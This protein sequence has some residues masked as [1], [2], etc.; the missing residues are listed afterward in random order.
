M[1][2]NIS[3]ILHILLPPAP[4]Y[5]TRFNFVSKT[6]DGDYY[7]I[8]TDCLYVDFIRYPFRDRIEKE[9]GLYLTQVYDAVYM[10]PVGDEQ[11][12]IDYAATTEKYT[13]HTGMT[14]VIPKRISPEVEKLFKLKI[15][16]GFLH[17]LDGDEWLVIKKENDL[18]EKL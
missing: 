12:V 2:M 15:E 14:C 17:K 7:Y 6:G 1:K 3:D 13:D 16:N 18:P 10:Y 8:L 5:S 11:D 9:D 4:L